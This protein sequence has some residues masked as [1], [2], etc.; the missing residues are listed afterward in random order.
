MSKIKSIL[1]M[2]CPA[3]RTGKLFPNQNMFDY[4]FKMNSSCSHC[5]E[6]FE[7]EPGFYY[8]AMFLSYV[9]FGILSLIVV[10][11]LILLFK[12]EW[13]LALVCLAFLLALTF[14]LQFRLARSVWIHLM[15][16]F[17]PKKK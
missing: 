14:V 5:N 3:C 10:G 6:D 13:R 8:G 12:I 16:D 2:T 15:V 4:S 7:R 11:T 9:M 17:N 1:N